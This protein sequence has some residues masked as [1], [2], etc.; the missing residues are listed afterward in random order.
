MQIADKT[1]GRYRIV[2]HLGSAHTPEEVAALMAL[3]RDK[4]HPGQGV[5]DFRRHRQTRYGP[6]GREVCRSQVIVDTIR[7]AYERL[8][9]IAVDDEAFFQLVLARLIEPTSKSDSVRVLSELGVGY[10]SPQH[11]PDV[12]QTR[13]R[14]Q[15]SRP[16]RSEV[17]RLLSGYDRDQVSSSTTSLPCTSRQRKT[18]C[19]SR[20]SAKE[21]RVDPQIVVGRDSSLI[22]QGSR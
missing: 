18:V 16:D 10:C 7:A 2:E 5:L 17:F 12:S 14:P 6:R 22:E 3:G 19:E 13:P 11:V 21:R 20:I 15:L 4:L 8:G 9:F 1:G